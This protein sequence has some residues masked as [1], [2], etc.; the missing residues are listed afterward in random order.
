MKRSNRIQGIGLILLGCLIWLLIFYLVMDTYV[1]GI[2]AT[3]NTHSYIPFNHIDCPV[4]MNLGESTQL[5]VTLLTPASDESQFYTFGFDSYHFQAELLHPT[6]RVFVTGGQPTEISWRITPNVAGKLSLFVRANSKKDLSSS[7]SSYAFGTSR[8]QGC[9]VLV[10]PFPLAGQGIILLG[11]VC[12]LTGFG[13]LFPG[14]F[15]WLRIR[16]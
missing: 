3:I 6:S 8:G 12:I 7:S 10:F 5:T 4:V 13:H 9:G 14:L 15:A 1:K 16:G 11:L 2:F